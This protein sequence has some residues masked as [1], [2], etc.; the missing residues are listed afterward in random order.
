MRI[1]PQSP[2]SRIPTQ[3]TTVW[4]PA[5]SKEKEV[6]QRLL[7]TRD[8]P[9]WFLDLHSS[10]S[11]ANK[12]RSR[13]KLASERCPFSPCFSHAHFLV[14]IHIVHFSVSGHKAGHKNGDST[15]GGHWL[16]PESDR[17]K[18]T[19]FFWLKGWQVYS[20]RKWLD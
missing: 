18:K 2:H 15:V 12:T 5:S 8:T 16:E 10:F 7:C 6:K 19:A 3:Q 1:S 13:P 11:S 17:V 9:V 4:W 20:V 14:T